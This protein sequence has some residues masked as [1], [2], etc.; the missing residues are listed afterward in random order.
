MTTLRWLLLFV[1]C[2]AIPAAFAA[3]VKI[4]ALP[5]ASVAND[6]DELPANQSGTTNKVTAAQLATLSITNINGATGTAGP[7]ETWQTLNA[8]C[9]G[10]KTTTFATCM[11][12]NGLPR[13]T[14]RFEYTVLWESNTATT[15]IKFSVGTPSASDHYAATW[16]F[17][18]TGTT[19]LAGTVDQD[20]N[21]TT[22][23]IV[24]H[25]S[26]RTNAGA[27]GPVGDVDTVNVVQL[28]H[29]FGIIR[30]TSSA[31]ASLYFS[32]AA[33]TT[34]GITVASD[35]TLNLRRVL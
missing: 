33:E 30:I 9:A 31:N 13:G 12:T 7:R 32:A 27:L 19:A 18:G 20:L 6:T 23:A 35:T 29:I 22:G 11:T 16:W 21:A 34:G 1:L 2:V 24:G 17:N 10:N 28:S 8:N 25:E 5:A 14:Y 3:D 4:S 15:G 26:V